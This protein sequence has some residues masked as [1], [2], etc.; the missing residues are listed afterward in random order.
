MPNTFQD[1]NG[2]GIQVLD[3]APTGNAS[4]VLDENFQVI[5]DHMTSTASHG[6]TGAVVGTTNTQT[7]TNK[8]IAAGSNTIT[9]IGDGNLTTGINAAKI[10]DGSVSN[11][12]FQYINSVTS[13]V[14]TQL[15]G[16]AS[17][18]SL[19]GY[20]P[21]TGGSLSGSFTIIDSANDLRGLFNS[22]S[23]MGGFSIASVNAANSAVRPLSINPYGGNVGIGLLSSAPESNL[24][25]YK[26]SSAVNMRLQ[27]DT[28]Q[29]AGYDIFRG[30]TQC[31]NWFLNNSDNTVY[32]GTTTA[33]SLI[34]RTNASDV[35]TLTSGGYVGIGT[36]SPASKLQ[37]NGTIT[38][39]SIT[40]PSGYFNL[41]DFGANVSRVRVD[42]AYVFDNRAYNLFAHTIGTSDDGTGGLYTLQF[43]ASN[44]GWIEA[45]A[46]IADLTTTNLYYLRR[47]WFVSYDG[48][49]ITPSSLVYDDP[50]SSA[51]A[52]TA[53][54]AGGGV[55]YIALTGNTANNNLNVSFTIE[56]KFNYDGS[57]PSGGMY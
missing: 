45:T 44:L 23:E 37:V 48:S 26:P 11:T 43:Y 21:L 53:T 42:Q 34:L 38:T 33:S 51:Y 28:S 24:H 55:L 36:V 29:Y 8:T 14:Q 30:G 56:H 10:A 39:A 6:A 57:A 40:H 52:L 41:G 15:D 47:R 3:P 31:A 50:H 22:F 13:N 54:D 17:T 35:I 32:M 20:L 5:G 49:V 2:T 4:S 27:T 16:K 7:L 19:S 9:G 18:G 12:E 46:T 25:V 1:Y